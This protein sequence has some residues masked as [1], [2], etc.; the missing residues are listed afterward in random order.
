MLKVVRES[1]AK[2]DLVDI[3][4]YVASDNLTAADRLMD[5]IET[6]FAMLAAQPNAGRSRPELAASLRS[7]PVG[8]YAIFYR[9][10]ETRIEVVRVLSSYRD[11]TRDLFQ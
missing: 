3:W 4:L 2:A 7:I 11:V 5:E 9:P 1:H 10:T 8:A 6:A